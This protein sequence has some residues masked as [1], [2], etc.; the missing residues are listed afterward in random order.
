[1]LNVE[2]GRRFLTVT[3]SGA[4]PIVIDLGDHASQAD[5]LVS[6]VRHW[7]GDALEVPPNQTGTADAARRFAS[8]VA[9]DP[10]S[11]CATRSRFT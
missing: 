10:Q 2:R 4:D 6:S 7:A 3:G 11:R 1:M 9:A 5:E 8:G